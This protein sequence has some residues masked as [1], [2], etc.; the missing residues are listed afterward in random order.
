MT[1]IVKNV[2]KLLIINPLY[3]AKNAWYILCVNVTSFHLKTFI[4]F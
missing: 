2:H 3:A 1:D 4:V